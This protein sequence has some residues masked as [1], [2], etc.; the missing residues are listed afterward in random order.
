MIQAENMKTYDMKAKSMKG[1]DL[2]LNRLH[3]NKN[4]RIKSLVKAPNLAVNQKG[5]VLFIALIAL[6]VMSLAAA[7]LIRSVDSSVLVAGN[8][9]FKQSAMM[10]ADTGIAQAYTWINGNAAILDNDATADGYYPVLDDTM[11]LSNASNWDNTHSN[12]VTADID[13]RSGNDTRY[14]LQRMCRSTG[15][16]TPSNCLVGVGN[17]AANSKGAK[18]Y[19]GFGNA[20]GS[21]NAVVY[22]VTVRVTGPK[23]T[24]SYL[25]AFIY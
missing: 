3:A 5:L 11:V 18:S 6:V 19:G 24:T 13:D 17:S 8:L 16:V 23:N 1:N 14:I 12:S 25:Q 15:A 7:A 10:S 2:M 20:T 9:A 21:A 22:R 4:N